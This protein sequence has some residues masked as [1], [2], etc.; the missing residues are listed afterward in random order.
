MSRRQTLRFRNTPLPR[1]WLM[2]DPRF[3]DDLLSAIKRLP[4][5]SGVIFRH[6]ELA[7]SARKALFRQV[8]RIC[9]QRGHVLLLAGDERTARAWNAD[10]YHSREDG[11]QSKRSI[12]S[13]AVHDR[14]ELARALRVGADLVLIS[15]VFA[16]ASH[17]DTRPLGRFTFTALA[18]QAGGNA[19]IAMGGMN[20]R[21]A[22]TLSNRISHGWAAIDAFRN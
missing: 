5:R 18:K 19:V 7:D 20:A 9:R 22:A 11:R 10:G 1:V 21:K 16:T 17:P 13:A 3:G 6:Y 4:F 15:P 8:Q 12:Q 2:T 14:A